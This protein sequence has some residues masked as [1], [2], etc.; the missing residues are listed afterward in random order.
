MSF[1]G[2]KSSKSGI[3]GK[4]PGPP[5]SGKIQSQGN[6]CQRNGKG[7]SRIIPLTDIPLTP[8]RFLPSSILHSPASLW[9][10][11]AA[12]GLPRFFA[13]IQWKRLSTKRLHTT[14]RVFKAKPSQTQSNPVKPFFLL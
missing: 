10:R 7:A 1:L 13:E 2:C 11:L 5:F 3:S 9:F 8:L 6:V 12:L 14:N 4:I